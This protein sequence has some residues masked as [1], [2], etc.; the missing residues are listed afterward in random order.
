MS[1]VKSSLRNVM[2]ILLVAIGVW[3]AICEFENYLARPLSID[4]AQ[5]LE[6]ERGSSLGPVIKQL[7]A[8]N[9]LNHP[10]LLQ[11]YVR[12]T[13]RGH[14]IQAG[15]YLLGPGTTPLDLL[16]MLEQGHV[17]MHSITLVEGWT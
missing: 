9:L 8:R 11:L 14:H 5:E 10:L 13:G 17:R 12:A 1:S 15:E 16:D 7:A 4:T 3:I 6:V 2:A